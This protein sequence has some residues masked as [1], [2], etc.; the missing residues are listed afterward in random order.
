[1]NLLSG[2]APSHYLE[3]LLYNEPSEQFG[4]SHADSSVT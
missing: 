2:V 1:M 4:H 3:V